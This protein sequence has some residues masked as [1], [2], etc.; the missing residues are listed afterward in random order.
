MGIIKCS[1]ESM[2]KTKIKKT[3][4]CPNCGHPQYCGC[5]SCRNHGL[6]PEGTKPYHWKD[7]EL[8]VCGNCGFIQ[9][10][11]WWLTLE[12]DVMIQKDQQVKQ[13]IGE[14]H[15]NVQGNK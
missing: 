1:G 7:G 4:H 15:D 2:E 9:H 5:E 13:N 6:L 8:I 3:I 14:N 11:D 10:C 12:G